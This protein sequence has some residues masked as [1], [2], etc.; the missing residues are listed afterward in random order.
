MKKRLRLEW[1]RSEAVHFNMLKDV[2][3]ELK[4]I[5]DSDRNIVDRLNATQAKNTLTGRLRRRYV[6]LVLNR[7][8]KQMEDRLEINHR[9][10]VGLHEYQVSEHFVQRLLNEYRS[11]LRCQNQEIMPMLIQW[12]AQNRMLESNQSLKT[13]NGE[14]ENELSDRSRQSSK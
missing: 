11:I 4:D 14:I 13:S 2:Y 1:Y 9:L 6:Q 5:V 12:G 3:R 10:H 7:R 8:L